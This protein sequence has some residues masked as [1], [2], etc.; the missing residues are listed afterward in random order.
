MI[1]Y[2]TLRLID[3]LIGLPPSRCMSGTATK[4]SR[5]PFPIS[6]FHSEFFRR[7]Y[8]T[9]AVAAA[10]AV[11]VNDVSFALDG[12]LVAVVVVVKGDFG[13]HLLS[14]RLNGIDRCTMK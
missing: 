5:S 14:R 13:V 1:S 11:V 2:S 7:R 4:G 10:A 3:K 8:D 12:K 6:G 9:M